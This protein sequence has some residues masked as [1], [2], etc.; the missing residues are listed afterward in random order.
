[1]KKKVAT[2][3]TSKYNNSNCRKCLHYWLRLSHETCTNEKI[4]IYYNKKK[5]VGSMC[6]C[7]DYEPYID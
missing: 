2:V 3:H 1:M 5:K 6:T 4:K 7:D